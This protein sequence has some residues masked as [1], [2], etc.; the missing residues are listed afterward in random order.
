M[1]P[2][3]YPGSYPMG[4]PP[5]PKQSGLGSRLLIDGFDVSGDVG[6]LG[7]IGVSNDELD[8]TGIDKLAKERMLGARD[9][10]IEFTA[11]FNPSTDAVHKVVSTLPTADRVVTYLQGVLAGNA[12]ASLVSK[13]M[14]YDGERGTDGAFT[15]EVSAAANGFGLDWSVQLTPGPRTDTTATN[16]PG[17]DL[18]SAATAFGLQ[19]YLH[20]LAFTGTS[21]TVKLQHSNDNGAGDAW[22]DLPGATFGAQTAKGAARVAT[23]PTQSVKRWLRV[24][25]TGTFTN[26]R[27]AVV[28]CRNEAAVRV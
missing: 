28:A 9:G 12:A 20:V 24:V 1:Y 23:S 14:N 18:G 4:A 27:F 3:G 10:G 22:A 11:Y 26:C 8:A 25:T 15:F 17:V 16:G 19:A 7:R 6:A 5:V 2:G 13:Q 21:A